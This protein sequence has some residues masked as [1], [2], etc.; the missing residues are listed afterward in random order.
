MQESLMSDRFAVQGLYFP[1]FYFK[2]FDLACAF[3]TQI[4]GQPDVDKE[5]LKG[6]QLGNT[7]LTFFPSEQNVP[8]EGDN[9]RNAEFAIQ[10]HTPP[11]VD[12]LFN[13][14]VAAGAKA[15]CEPEDT[16]MYEE[17]RFSGVDDPFGIRVDIFC[18][19]QQDRQ[20]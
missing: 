16:W 2:D 17:M 11:E 8:S 6:W 10:V 18:P 7:W 9:P 20:D 5:K 15:F 19:L 13:A 12:V 3:Y 4:L 1:T 14:F